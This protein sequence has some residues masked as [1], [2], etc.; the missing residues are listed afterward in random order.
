MQQLLA[1]FRDAGSPGA[2][3]GVSMAALWH[4]LDFL[5]DVS[6]DRWYMRDWS[7]SCPSAPGKGSSSSA[8]SASILR[9][10]FVP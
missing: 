10:C 8:S 6:R 3:A 1:G 7:S 2:M 5:G 9:R 4:A